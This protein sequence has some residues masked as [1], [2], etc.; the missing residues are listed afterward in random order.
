MLY[1]TTM[2][3]ACGAKTIYRKSSIKPPRGGTYLIADTSGGLREGGGAY[4]Q[5]QVTRIIMIAFQLITPYFVGS[6][7]NFT[8]QI[9]KFD[10]IFI[11]NH[12]KINM[13]AFLAK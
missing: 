6:G 1:S 7:C 3:I 9:R 13:Q 5:N 11:P 4:S 10:T 12:M 8:S 2:T